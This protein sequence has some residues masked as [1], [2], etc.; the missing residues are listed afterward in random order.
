MFEIKDHPEVVWIVLKDLLSVAD[1]SPLTEAVQNLLQEG[2][3][4]FVADL[5][6]VAHISSLG[7]SALIALLTRVRSVGGELVLCQLSERVQQLLILTRLRST[8][9]VGESF[10]EALGFLQPSNR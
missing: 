6:E 5:S 8:F 3:R 7:L 1:F 4:E 2:K 9:Q 10:E